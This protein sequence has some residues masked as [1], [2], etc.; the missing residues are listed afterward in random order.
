M[1]QAR[2]PRADALRDALR[3]QASLDLLVLVPAADG[4]SG[5]T[6][7]AT[8]RDGTVGV[9]KVSP[10]ATDDSVGRRGEAVSRL[11]RRGCSLPGRWPA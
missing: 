1:E 2:Q 8:G 10:T 11:R 5:S 6:F 9:L 4:E 3:E 7:L